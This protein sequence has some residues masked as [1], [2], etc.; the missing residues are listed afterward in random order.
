VLHRSITQQVLPT[1][2]KKRGRKFTKMTVWRAIQDGACAS[3]LNYKSVANRHVSSIRNLEGDV[4]ICIT[5]QLHDLGD[6]HGLLWGS[7]ESAEVRKRNIQKESVGPRTN[8]RS[9]IQII[10]ENNSQS[11]VLNQLLSLLFKKERGKGKRKGKEKN[12]MKRRNA[13]PNDLSEP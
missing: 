6:F 5:S 12:E 10:H 11:T 2:G 4:K 3:V 7:D 13:S 8:L 1:N 9:H